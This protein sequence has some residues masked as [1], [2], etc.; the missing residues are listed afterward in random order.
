MQRKI[1][2]P[3][4]FEKMKI[5]IYKIDMQNVKSHRVLS[6]RV[7]AVLKSQFLTL[8]QRPAWLIVLVRDVT[9]EPWVYIR[10][11]CKPGTW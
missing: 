8:K 7:F 5:S 6:T 1:S 4:N 10:Y 3:Q 9:D 2:K 11:M